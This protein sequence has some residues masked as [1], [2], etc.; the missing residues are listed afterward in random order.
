MAAV[1]TLIILCR[2]TTLHHDSMMFE[3]VLYQST[4]IVTVGS[5]SYRV[6][7]YS[8]LSDTFLDPR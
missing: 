6:Y 5:R 1:L 3:T 4:T 8:T 7:N 2:L